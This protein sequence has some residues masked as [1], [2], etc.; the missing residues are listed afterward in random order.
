M[1]LKYTD[2]LEQIFHLTNDLA[3]GGLA[4]Q[5]VWLDLF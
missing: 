5:V 2:V 4:E 1:L 3:V